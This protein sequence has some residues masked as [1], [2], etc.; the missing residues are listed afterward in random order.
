MG[1]GAGVKHR[2]ILLLYLSAVFASGFVHDLR[3]LG[4]AALL[5]MVLGGRDAVTIV[6]RSLVAVGL[7]AATVTLAYGLLAL[8]RG[9]AID[10]TWTLRTNLRALLLTSMTLLLVRR[11][12]TRRAF[13]PWPGLQM[14]L[15][16]IGAQV[17]L[18]QRELDDYRLGL[19]SRSPQRTN[20]VTAARHAAASGAHLLGRALHD[21]DEIALAL[22][23]RGAW[24]DRG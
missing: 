19:R 6:R 14:L 5:V 18:L 23:A 20:T 15:T 10:W 21:A 7:F 1:E 11:L 2:L 4:A 3:V 12:D 17:R 13:A 9:E 22:R 16:L 8:W 24:H